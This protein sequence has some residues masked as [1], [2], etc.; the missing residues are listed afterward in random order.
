MT[1][2]CFH[3]HEEIIDPESYFQAILR[4]QNGKDTLAFFHPECC[5]PFAKRLRTEHEYRMVADE[6]D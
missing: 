6:R 3:C 1:I 5:E 4:D 2:N